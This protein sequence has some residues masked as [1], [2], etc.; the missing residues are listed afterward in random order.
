[1]SKRL[2]DIE[3]R[4][5]AIERV[6]SGILI[7]LKQQKQEESTAIVSVPDEDGIEWPIRKD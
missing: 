2:D 7:E 1:M 5:D 4:L 6:V 3:K